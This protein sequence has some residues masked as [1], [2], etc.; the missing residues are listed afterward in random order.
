[1][2]LADCPKGS[3][4][5]FHAMT[6]AFKTVLSDADLDW[7]KVKEHLE[8]IQDDLRKKAKDRE[9]AH[10]ETRWMAIVSPDKIFD[11]VEWALAWSR[12]DLEEVLGFFSED[13]VY[14]DETFGWAA[15]SKSSIRDL[16]SSLFHAFDWEME[17]ASALRDADGSE[18]ELHWART[19]ARF[20]GSETVLNLRG[21]TVRGKSSLF[22]QNG[23]IWK[24]V[25]SSNQ[26]D[27]DRIALSK[28]GFDAPKTAGNISTTETDVSV[29]RIR[30]LKVLRF[31]PKSPDNTGTGHEE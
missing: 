19:G 8:L 17:V 4:H 16:F 12:R 20:P 23:K 13:A 21:G 2:Y 24:C 15:K 9:D 26:Q 11:Y 5:L 27:I 31:K 6:E 7:Q 28:I 14:L 10:L 30:L 29:D 3:A 22:V 25:D 18:V 1:M